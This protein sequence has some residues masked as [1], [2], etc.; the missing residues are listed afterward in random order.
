MQL[1]VNGKLHDIQVDPDTPLLWVLRDAVGSTGTKFGCGA[2][3][4]G[5]CSVLLDGQLTRSCV[6]PVQAVGSKVVTTIE[7]IGGG[8]EHPLQTAWITTQAPQCGYCQSGMIVAA[9]ALLAT[10]PN[11]S[12][13]DIDA[14]ITNLCRCGTYSRIRSAIHLAARSASDSARAEP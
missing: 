11:P 12:D 6:F 14:A 7:G 2:G 13:T 8:K 10:N 5:A 1:N 3:V 9:A 4:C